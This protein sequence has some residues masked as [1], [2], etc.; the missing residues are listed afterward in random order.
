MVEYFRGPFDA[1]SPGPQGREQLGV[2]DDVAVGVAGQHDDQGPVNAQAIASGPAVGLAEAVG[3][4]PGP[5]QP[6]VVGPRVLP[7]VE[8]GEIAA[9]LEQSRLDSAGG[10]RK[11]RGGVGKPGP[12]PA[13]A[14]RRARAART[15]EVDQEQPMVPYLFQVW[16]Q[17][18]DLTFGALARL[19]PAQ[20]AVALLQPHESPAS[21]ALS[22]FL[23]AAEAL[24]RAAGPAGQHAPAEAVRAGGGR[25]APAR[26][27]D[28]GH[29]AGG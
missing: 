18:G 9:G 22:R 2:P 7:A 19:M 14:A 16:L 10:R 3:D 27:Q 8:P 15:V 23:G 12:S 11:R 13:L 1:E 28:V 5:G 29:H 26:R 6:W 20:T 4:V 25:L 21:A 24:A 17:Y